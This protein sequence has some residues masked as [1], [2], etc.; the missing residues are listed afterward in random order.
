[1]IRTI[2]EEKTNKKQKTKQTNKQN[3]QAKIKNWTSFYLGSLKFRH[4][5]QTYCSYTNN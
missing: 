4:F 2:W 3:Q 5:C 1:M